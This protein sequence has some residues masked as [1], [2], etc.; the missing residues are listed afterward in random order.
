MPVF[1]ADYE[2]LK[3]IGGALMGLVTVGATIISFFLARRAAKQKAET[4]ARQKEYSQAVAEARQYVDQK[5]SDTTSE[6]QRIDQVVEFLSSTS[7]DSKQ[8]QDNDANALWGAVDTISKNCTRHQSSATQEALVAVRRDLDR[9]SAGLDR[10]T[11]EMRQY[12]AT[13]SYRH[14]L[15][16]WTQTINTLRQSIHDLAMLVKG[17]LEIERPRDQGRST[18]A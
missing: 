4:E 15:K 1:A 12:V 16:L 13:D 14:D 18:D 10:L 8:Q 9:L 17:I 7:R 5:L 6:L 3:L 2:T 11:S